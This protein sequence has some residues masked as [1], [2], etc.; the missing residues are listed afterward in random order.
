M[1]EKRAIFVMSHPPD[2]DIRVFKESRALKQASY[3]TS[4]LYWDREGRSNRVRHTGDYDEELCLRFKAPSGVMLLFFLPVWWI[5]VFV[6]L[7]VKKWDIVHAVNV[8]SILPSLMAGR[9]KRKPVIYEILDVYEGRLPRMLG[10]ICMGFDKLFMR[11]ADGIIVADDAQIE[12]IGGIPNPRVVA[13]YDSPPDIL[14]SQDASYLGYH[15]NKPFTLF[16]AGVLY[17]NRRLN[18]DKVLG[19]IQDMEGVKLIIAG[20]GDLVDEIK[21]WSYRLPDKV[22]FVGQ[23][24]Y[25]E[26]IKRG[27]RAH[28]FFVLRDPVVPTSRFTCGSTLFNAMICG[29]PI[30][31]NQGTSTTKKVSEENCG[32]AV[33]GSDVEEIR[34]AILKLR[35]NPQLCEELGTNARRAYEQR[36]SWELMG[37]RLVTFYHE[38]IREGNSAR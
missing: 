5:Y 19:A 18:L 35:D 26:V 28:L 33:N 9:L 1:A 7:L 12:G 24:D 25:A 23:I 27:I 15:E 10:A 36:Y 38:L 22:E 8:H 17:K 3:M 4:L 21:G 11:L 13:I 31:V 30:L 16:Y 29:K 37:Q 20:Y 6:R 14:D 34:Q 2:Q 32:L